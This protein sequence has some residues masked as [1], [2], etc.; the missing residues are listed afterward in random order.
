MTV[1][2][3][4]GATLLGKTVLKLANKKHP[5]L[6]VT[7]FKMRGCACFSSNRHGMRWC[8]FPHMKQ[9]LST[10]RALLQAA[11]IIS[12][13]R[14]TQASVPT[15]L[16]RGQVPHLSEALSLWNIRKHREQCSAGSSWST[17]TT[18]ARKGASN[19]CFK[20]WQYCWSCPLV[21]RLEPSSEYKH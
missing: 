18:L 10:V 11:W 1:K 4:N 17:I 19:P 8:Y 6:H 5:E 2:L 13:P 16:Y 15:C 21:W 12:Y 9:L 20:S 7:S 14:G 3:V